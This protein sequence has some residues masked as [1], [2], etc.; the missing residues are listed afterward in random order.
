M[1]RASLHNISSYSSL[2]LSEESK[3]ILPWHIDL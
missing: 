3:R 2:K 1:G